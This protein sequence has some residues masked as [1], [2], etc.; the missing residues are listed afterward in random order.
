M[1]TGGLSG[2]TLEPSIEGLL[3]FPSGR[4]LLSNGSEREVHHA[5]P[6]S[7]L[8]RG[9]EIVEAERIAGPQSTSFFSQE[10]TLTRQLP[11]SGEIG[12]QQEIG[13]KEHRIVPCLHL[14]KTATPRFS[15]AETAGGSHSGLSHRLLAMFYGGIIAVQEPLHPGHG[16]NSLS[17]F[18]IEAKSL[19]HATTDDIFILFLDYH[20]PG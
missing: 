3:Q 20:H 18:L 7:Y 17:M 10:E 4:K 11:G 15:G 2:L 19:V 1:V 8:K 5:G 9:A 14:L 6:E 16:E 13:E 12:G